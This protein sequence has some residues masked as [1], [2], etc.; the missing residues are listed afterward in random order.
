MITPAFV[1]ETH[2]VN[3]KRLAKRYTKGRNPTPWHAP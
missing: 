2:P 1:L 3:L